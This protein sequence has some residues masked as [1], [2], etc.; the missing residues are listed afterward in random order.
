MINGS[1]MLNVR[2]AFQSST[3]QLIKDIQDIIERNNER[4]DKDFLVKIS[5]K[6]LFV[7]ENK[8]I[9]EILH[10]MMT[11][12]IHMTFRMDWMLAMSQKRLLLPT[13]PRLYV[14]FMFCH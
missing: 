2:K 10:E 7:P 1:D 4:N 3:L 13:G 9:S 12:R 8:S 5:R 6:I 11:K 14:G